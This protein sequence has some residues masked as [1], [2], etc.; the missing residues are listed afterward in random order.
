MKSNQDGLYT[1]VADWFERHKSSLQADISRDLGHGRA[2]KR[3][4]I[5]SE[6]L[7]FI[8]AAQEWVGLKSV[9]YVESSRWVNQEHQLSKRYYIS[10]LAGYSAAQL[11]HFIRRH[12]GAARAGHRE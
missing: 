11:G 12:C 10:S 1:Q 9:I 5:V 3:T 6:K 7:N 2:E 8:D 4:V